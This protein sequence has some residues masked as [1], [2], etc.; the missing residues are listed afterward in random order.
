M[1]RQGYLHPG[2]ERLAGEGEVVPCFELEGLA[3]NG[4]PHSFVYKSLC[5]LNVQLSHEG[6]VGRDKKCQV[7]SLQSAYSEEINCP[8]IMP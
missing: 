1:G 5:N 2:R 3:S 7:E 6:F 4:E 8:L